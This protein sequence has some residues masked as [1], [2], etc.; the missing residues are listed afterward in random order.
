M[1]GSLILPADD[2]D[3]ALMPGHW[4]LARLGKHVLRP[5]G[6][7]LTRWLLDALALGPGDR[8][9][10]LAA[11]QGATAR[12]T[13]ARSPAA[14][15]GVDRDPA[16]VAA[17]STLTTAGG[18][19]VRAVHSDPTATG[20]PSGSATVVYGEATLTTRPD[21]ARRVRP[22]RIVRNGGA[23]SPSS[24][25]RRPIRAVTCWSSSAPLMPPRRGA[26]GGR[27]A[28]G[29]GGRGERAQPQGRKRVTGGVAR[30][31]PGGR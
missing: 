21:P 1:T 13:L 25:S 29:A 8:V 23:S 4:L 2:P 24:T 16:A 12:L 30:R 28:S 18:R 17:L 31:V 20:Q 7:E 15:T 6:V 14:Y 3:T 5:G 9:L 26:H 10:E 11:G 27:T 22:D 19:D